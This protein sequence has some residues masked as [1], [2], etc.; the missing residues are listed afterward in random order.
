MGPDSIYC[1]S[2]VVFFSTIWAMKTLQEHGYLC[3]MSLPINNILFQP[4]LQTQLY[5]VNELVLDLGTQAEDA[6][7]YWGACPLPPSCVVGF[8][9]FCRLSD[10][11]IGRS[12]LLYPGAPCSSSHLLSNVGRP[13]AGPSWLS[14]LPV[15]TPFLLVRK[16]HTQPLLVQ[17]SHFCCYQCAQFAMASPSIIPACWESHL[18]WLIFLC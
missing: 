1:Q 7:L 12:L 5:S 16:C 15:A 11:L 2:P 13:W 14:F 4:A 10:S 18:W 17:G 6:M 8:F 3:Q 9:G